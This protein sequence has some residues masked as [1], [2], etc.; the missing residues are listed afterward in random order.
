M[1][2]C[3]IDGCEN[4][5]DA[6][7]WCRKHY[8]RF[9]RHGD[10]LHL[11][12]RPYSMPLEELV[13][14][15]LDNCKTTDSGCM[16][17]NATLSNKGYSQAKFQDKTIKI[18][19]LVM[20]HFFGPKPDGM[21]VLH[22]DICGGDRRCIN[23]NHLRYGTNKENVTDRSR[24]DRQHS[25]LTK[26]KVL[27]IRSLYSSGNFTQRDLADRFSISQ[28]NISDIVNRKRWKHI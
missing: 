17:S 19:S 10:P 12:R 7:G 13:K 14:Y 4:P 2:I 24:L 22:S 9:K 11:E 23:L 5:I 25:K 26:N 18:A 3:N 16:I 6:R 27:E 20:R 1:K 15:C 28:T 8:K 21:G